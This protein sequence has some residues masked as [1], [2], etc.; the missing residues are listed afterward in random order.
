MFANGNEVRIVFDKKEF[1]QLATRAIGSKFNF[2][3]HRIQQLHVRF[4]EVI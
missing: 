1:G 3:R 2:S 4:G